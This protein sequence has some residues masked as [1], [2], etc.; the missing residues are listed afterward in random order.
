MVLF[1]TTLLAGAMWFGFEAGCE[2]MRAA[3][4]RPDLPSLIEIQRRIGA[5][6]DG[7]YGPE[8]E[9]LWD[10]AYCDQEAMKCFN[11]KMLTNF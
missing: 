1:V 7:I 6:P 9:R 2:R 4:P 8:T 10:R 11:E 3:Q 5:V